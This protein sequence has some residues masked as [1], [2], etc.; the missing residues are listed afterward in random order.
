[1]GYVAPAWAKVGSRLE[2]EIRGQ[3]RPAE[4]VKKPFYRAPHR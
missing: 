3:R 1:M 4:V 2:I